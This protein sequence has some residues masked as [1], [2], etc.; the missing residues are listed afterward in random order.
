M[1]S[2]ADRA[3]RLGL[4]WRAMSVMRQ[5]YEQPSDFEVRWSTAISL[6]RIA[7]ILEDTIDQNR[8][9]SFNVRRVD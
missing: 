8:L 7:D 4:E 6:K 2:R 5:S 1:S 9:S 3:N